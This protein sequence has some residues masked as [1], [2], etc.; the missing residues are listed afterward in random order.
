[1]AI[2]ISDYGKAKVVKYEID[3]TFGTMKIY[4]LPEGIDTEKQ[5]FDGGQLILNELKLTDGYQNEV[6]SLP[7]VAKTK[8]KIGYGVSVIY[9]SPI[10]LANKPQAFDAISRKIII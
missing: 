3:K 2:H 6:F 9:K 5:T 1:M 10:K 4:S 8:D 7:P